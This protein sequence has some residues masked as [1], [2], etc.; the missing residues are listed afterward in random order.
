M[1][2]QPAE[3]PIGS[4]FSVDA[5]LCAKRA[6]QPE[7]VRFDA[8]MP[9]HRHG[10]NTR[11]RAKPLDGGRWRAEGFLFHMPGRWQFTVEIDTPA[12]RERLTRDVTLE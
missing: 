1:A 3:V 2:T 12:G 4:E 6:A 9:A 8:W 11:P 10:M 5:L 7:A